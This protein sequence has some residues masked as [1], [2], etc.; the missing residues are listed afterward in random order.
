MDYSQYTDEQLVE[1]S[2]KDQR[3]MD[4]LISKYKGLV[5][6]SIKSLFPPSQRRDQFSFAQ[7]KQ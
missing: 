7:H 6:S 1:I 5:L 2:D 3:A 4:Y